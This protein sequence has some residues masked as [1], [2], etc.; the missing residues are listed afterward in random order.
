MFRSVF[1][2]YGIVKA[3]QA[4][5]GL[6]LGCLVFHIHRQ[7]PLFLSLAG[8]AWRLGTDSS[9]TS[10][11]GTSEEGLSQMG[12]I[13]PNATRGQNGVV[14]IKQLAL[15]VFP[16]PH[17]SECRLSLKSWGVHTAP[18][19]RRK[20]GLCAQKSGWYFYHPVFRDLKFS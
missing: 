4:S 6:L 7:M 10:A 14:R 1:L 17:L 19:P 3:E 8:K 16:T 13:R 9:V 18:L 11:C 2:L 20:S 5:S 15:A 12:K